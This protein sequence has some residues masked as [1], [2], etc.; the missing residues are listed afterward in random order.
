MENS[1]IQ[2]ESISYED[3]KA[4]LQLFA[5]TLPDSEKWAIFFQSS[6][7]AQIIEYISA[8]RAVIKYDNM[9]AIRENNIQFSKNRSSKIGSSQFLGYSA[10]RGENPI[11]DITF[12]PRG[13]GVYSAYDIIGTVKAVDIIVLEE[14][15]YN[16]GVEMTIRCV[17]GELG[18]EVNYAESDKL[19]LFKFKTPDMSNE[20][21]VFIDDTELNISD[22]VAD[23]LEGY[24]QVQTNPYGGVDVKYLNLSSF[25]TT[26]V[27]GSEIKVKFVKLNDL[28]YALSD[29]VLD[30]A[31]GV[32]VASSQYALYDA[33]ESDDSIT[34]NAPLRNETKLHVRGRKDNHKVLKQ[35]DSSLLDARGADIENVSAMMEIFYL[36]ENEIRY[37]PAEK[38]ELIEKFQP[39]RP[40]GLKPPIISEP[41]RALRKFKVVIYRMPNT[42]GDITAKV[43]E[44]FSKYE[45]ILNATINLHDIEAELE[46]ES[47]IKV[48]RISYNA[49]LWESN[50]GYSE[51][52]Q[53]RVAGSDLLYQ[54]ESHVYTTG[55]EEPEW[56]IYSEQKIIDGDTVWQAFVKDDVSEIARWE[57]NTS[58]TYMNKVRP[59]EPNGLAYRVIG[60]V[61]YSGESE[62]VWP[63]LAG[64]EVDDMVGTLAHDNNIVWRLIPREG[65]YSSWEPN[66]VYSGGECVIP[67][68]PVASDNVD[69][70]WQVFG[71]IRNSG[72]TI[73]EFPTS[74]DE[75]V[76]DGNI[77]WKAIDPE[78]VEIEIPESQYYVIETSTEIK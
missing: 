38:L 76:T 19:G 56:P 69:A 10:Y 72:P 11:V 25:D 27:T 61:S 8:L 12:I 78:E 62:P 14:V 26:Y 9:T 67:T 28:D 23:M 57:P 15:A 42:T 45:Y 35:L 37:T 24:A 20:L 52:S 46:A 66:K 58:Y 4:D 31:E 65:S 75:Q 73:P 34:V 50:T 68:D 47:Y 33:R 48:A 53:V 22:G 63:A 29:I 21:K 16:A 43:D 59:E 17:L 39:Y 1:I 64:A 55:A 41:H 60:F 49:D 40:N 44:V 36:R 32:L 51:G 6:G 18:E 71:F 77:I 30:E 70:M 13:T 74:V 3:V 7:G 5:D 54:V 2:N